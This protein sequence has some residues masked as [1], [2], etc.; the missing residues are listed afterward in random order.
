MAHRN[1]DGPIQGGRRGRKAADAQQQAAAVSGSVAEAD[2]DACTADAKLRMSGSR[3]V[4]AFKPR[5]PSS[6]SKAAAAMKLV[7]AFKSRM[8]SNGSP[9]AAAVK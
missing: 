2:S 4:A 5:I 6:G 9:A 1:L 7:A 8:P 3:L